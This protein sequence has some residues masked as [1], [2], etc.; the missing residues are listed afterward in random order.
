MIVA[1]AQKNRQRWVEEGR[2]VTEQMISSRSDMDGGSEQ[3]ADRR[4]VFGEAG[5]VD[6]SNSLTALAHESDAS[7]ESGCDEESLSLTGL[8]SMGRSRRLAKAAKA[9]SMQP[10]EN[11]FDAT[12]P[13]ILAGQILD[14]IHE[15][16]RLNLGKNDAGADGDV[17]VVSSAQKAITSYWQ[18]G[19]IMR[20]RA[21][22]LL[23]DVS[24]FTNMAQIFAVDHFKTFIN[25][26]FTEI[27]NIITSHGGEV[28]KFAGDALYAV[29]TSSIGSNDDACDDWDNQHS[30]AVARC[31]ACGSAINAKCNNYRVAQTYSRHRHGAN[32]GRRG[33]LKRQR[34]KDSIQS[35]H[36]TLGELRL[37]GTV[38]LNADGSGY[39]EKV[40]FFNVH[41]GISEGTVAGVNVCAPNRSEFFFIG[42]PMGEVAEAEGQATAGELVISS[43]VKQI[44]DTI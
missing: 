35:L 32:R 23:V 16:C 2:E 42:T 15:R 21:C 30:L 26:Y 37:E 12:V 24:G 4:N 39:E 29:W 28:A 14:T 36:K 41:C 7:I 19:S 44:L 1:N 33:A 10:R 27:I 43:S 18:T 25:D 6:S 17:H 13:R 31:V 8:R 3:M 22:I 38:N 9:K 20:Y 11:N 5:R 40:A 34:S